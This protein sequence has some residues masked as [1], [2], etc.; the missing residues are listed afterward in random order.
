LSRERALVALAPGAL[1]IA[2]PGPAARAQAVRSRTVACEPAAGQE[3]WRSAAAALAPVAASLRDENVDVTVVLSNHFVRY[4]LVAPDAK[5]ETAEEELAFARYCFARIHGERS[6]AWQV[7]LDR[8]GGAARL[9]SAVD[10]GLLR[11]LRDCF[12]TGA[13]A[14]LV[15]V[16]PYLMA[17][18]NRWR[19]RLRAASAALLLVE[20]GRACVAHL[21]SGRWTAVRSARGSFGG[22]PEW[23]QFLER[24]R[25]LDADTGTPPEVLVHAPSPAGSL[26]SAAGDWRFKPVADPGEAGPASRLDAYSAMAMCAS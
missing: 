26:S 1:A 10:D 6:A 7:R 24:E 19:Q 12:K 16:Q 9:A 15:S 5:L 8:G 14:R 23:A 11:A 18:F 17:A 22:A 25:Q 20:P 13:R 21:R 2:R 3:S 4:A